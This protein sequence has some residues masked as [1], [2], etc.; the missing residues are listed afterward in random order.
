MN[1]RDAAIELLARKKARKNYADFCR[2]VEPVE[3]PA[4]HHLIL[5]E[6]LDK[7]LYGKIRNLM[8]FMPPGSAKSTYGTVRYPA[9]YLGRSKKKSI[10]CCSYNEKLASSFGRK[11]R[12]LIDSRKCNNVFPGLGLTQD[13]KAK[14]EWETTDGG[15]YL[16]S[17]VGGGITGR[18][19]NIGF[20]DDPVK[21]RKESD[22]PTVSKDTW[23]WYLNDF[24]TRLKPK[25]SQ[26]IFQTRWGENDLSGRI[27]PKGWNGESGE[28]KGK[29]GK[30]WTVICIQAECTDPEKDILGRK[31]GEFLWPEFF[32]EEFWKETKY[33]ANKTDTRTWNSLYQQ[34]PATEE[35]TFF[36]R[37]WFNR[38]DITDIPKYLTKFGAADYA[39]T[40]GG[41]DFTEQGICGLD[42]KSDLYIIDWIS[43]QCESD[44][45]V[46]DLIKLHVNHKLYMFGAEVGQIK[47]CIAPWIT[48]R[49]REEKVFFKVEAMSHI[50]DKGANAQ[51]F[52]AMASSGKVYIPR[53]QWGNDL[54]DQ[55]VKFPAGS[56]DDKVDVC[57]LMGR[58][59]DK[60]ND[61]VVPAHKKKE[62]DSWNSSFGQENDC[63]DWKTV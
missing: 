17:G 2:Y 59:I 6:A 1:R 30:I 5:C 9:Y 20:I 52:R 35:G 39:V 33:A 32:D 42:E 8:V 38:Y 13:Q 7:V 22:S 25:A 16:A 44:V 43:R 41:G 62:R 27:L 21:G 50:G 51:V 12:N 3:L 34:N 23:D 54:V 60:I 19:A 58:L 18:R 45:W 36:K 49:Q 24:L 57:G 47:K 14:G 61:A 56:Y 46:D 31:K 63:N 29:D 15:F 4:K 28:F 48:R 53:T 40:E 26:I 10:L 11:T 55:L 37:E